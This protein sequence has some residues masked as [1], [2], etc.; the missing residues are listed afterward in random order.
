MRKITQ[1]ISMVG[2]AAL[3]LSLVGCTAM[4]GQR[5]R[6]ATSSVV[7]YLFPNKA[8]KVVPSVPYLALPLKVGMAFVPEV[9]SSPNSWRRNQGNRLNERE[10]MDLMDRVATEFKA[11]PFVDDI[12]IIPS[13]YL[14][15]KGGFENLD[16]I[17]TMHGIDV[18]VLLSY[19]QVQ[20]TDDSVFSLTYLTVV[21]AMVVEGE[22][23]DTSTMLDAAV[24]DIASRKMLF[25]APGTSQVKARAA[26]LHLEEELRKDSFTGFGLAADQLIVNLK[27]Q[28]TRF[29]AK[30]KERPEEYKVVHRKGYS[31]G[32]GGGSTGAVYSLLLLALGSFA[33]WRNRTK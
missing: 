26:P 8:V 5:K 29:Q 30:V 3:A 18:I 31:G 20:H 23:N 11:L 9:A 19:D 25:R 24:F 15:A 32:T 14:R 16:Q 27:D 28:L 22:R 2:V 33:L 13:A 1:G 6:R 7:E 21:G 12:E 10:R 17:K 4:D